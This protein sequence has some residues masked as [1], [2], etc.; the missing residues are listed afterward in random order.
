MNSAGRCRSSA[1]ILAAASPDEQFEC[2]TAEDV[3]SAPAAVAEPAGRSGAP[4]LPPGPAHENCVTP[5]GRLGTMH[6]LGLTFAARLPTYSGSTKGSPRRD[7]VAH[8]WPSRTRQ[9][10]PWGAPVVNPR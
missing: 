7:G 3:K 6:A 4:N 9:Q 1:V 5:R 2:A 8:R 10:Q